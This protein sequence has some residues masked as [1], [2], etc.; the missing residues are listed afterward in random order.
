M[1]AEI[2]T[3]PQIE[4]H[5]LTLGLDPV[6]RALTDR[7]L[8]RPLELPFASWDTAK[9]VQRLLYQWMRF[10]PDVKGFISIRLNKDLP[11]I[12]LIPRTTP[13]RRGRKGAT[14]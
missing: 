12:T 11:I 6:L 4:A 8:D 9:T 14:R 1:E 2:K 5:L 13:E 7:K 3:L 10:N